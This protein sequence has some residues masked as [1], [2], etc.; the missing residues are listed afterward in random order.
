MYDRKNEANEFVGESTEDA[1]SGAARFYGVEVG[2]LRVVVP[3]TG[4]V[5]GTG[6]RAVV[7]AI[8]KNARRAPERKDRGDRGDRGERRERR[9]RGERSGQ[10]PDRGGE[11]AASEEPESRAPVGE[12]RGTPQGEIGEMG[13]FLLKTIEK[14]GLGSFEISESSEGAFL[15]YEIRGEA[16]AA[17]G[18]GDGRAVDALQLLVNQVAKNTSEDPARIVVDVEGSTD[19]RRDDS[20]EK[21][22]DRAAKRALDTG[23][24]VALDPMNPRDR[25]IIHVTLR[26]R[27]GIA[28]MSVGK[29]RYR[30]VMV[31]PEGAPEYEEACETSSTP[32]S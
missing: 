6:G 12:S 7:V 9:P 17:L 4:T 32:R 30:Q 20:I 28:T 22:A 19:E 15:V 2:D 16:S 1:I 24:A 5:S 25:R 3:E 26:D 27:D 18:S 13:A 14:M 8:P 29:A 23:R 21:L 11:K 10:R 31:V